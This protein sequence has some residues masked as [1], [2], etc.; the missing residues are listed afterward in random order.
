MID[1]LVI[2]LHVEY[3]LFG[4]RQIRE[5]MLPRHLLTSLVIVQRNP[6]KS[7]RRRHYE[8]LCLIRH[9]G[10]FLTQNQADAS[11]ASLRNFF[12]G[13]KQNGHRLLCFAKYL[14]F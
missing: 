10:P 11:L 5:L 8:L 7:M 13:Q 3:F 12:R 14:C 2:R 6:E 9:L 1:V 4:D